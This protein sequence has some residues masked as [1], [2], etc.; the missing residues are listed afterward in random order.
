MS[1]EEKLKDTREC[2]QLTVMR[3][4]RLPIPDIQHEDPRG[5]G[6]GRLLTQR[7]RSCFRVVSPNRLG[8]LRAQL[9]GSVGWEKS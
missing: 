9:S 8:H 3:L 2:P 6:K 4:I 7:G 5:I 1:A